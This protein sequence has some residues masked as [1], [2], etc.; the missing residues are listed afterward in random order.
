MT[1]HTTLSALE[2][3]HDRETSAARERIEQAEEHIHY[4]RSQMIRLQ[5]HFSEVAR[6]AGVQDDPGFQYELR[7]VTAQIEDN[8]SAATRVVIRFDDELTELTARHHRE[9]DDLRQRLRQNG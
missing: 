1:E 9:H 3:A 2:D 7:R 6:A 5:E 8:V 4:Y